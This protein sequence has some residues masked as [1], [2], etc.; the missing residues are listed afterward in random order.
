MGAVFENVT[1][2]HGGIT[3]AVDEDSLEFALQEMDAEQ[4]ANQF[5]DV[6]RFGKRL[7]E[8][9]VNERP[10]RVEE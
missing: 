8:V 1:G 9:V 4:D 5:L 10:K 7:V 6:G 3:K 2:R